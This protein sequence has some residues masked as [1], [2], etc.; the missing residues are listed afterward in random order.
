MVIASTE[1]ALAAEV[2]IVG[3]GS[4]PPMP[5]GSSS[6]DWASKSPIEGVI[7]EGRKKK[8]AIAK[9]FC[10]ACLSGVD[11]N[12]D[13]RGGDP[14]DNPKIVRD[15]TNRFAMP[16]SD[17]QMLAYI[18]RMCRQE[19]EAQKVQEGLR[20]EIYHLQERVVEVE[21]LLEEKATDI[22]SLQDHQMLAYIKR[23]CRQ[24]VEAQKVQEGLRAE[25]YHLQERVVEVEHLLEEKATDIGSLQGAL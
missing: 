1:V 13:E 16:E 15:L 18:K 7:G 17:H 24:E 12:S 2:D 4:V 10:K 5:S 19:G 6:G 23:M 8:K 22:G 21:H 25:I 9:M 11:G 20:A 3:V 14:F